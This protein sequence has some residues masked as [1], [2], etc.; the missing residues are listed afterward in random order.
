MNRCTVGF[1]VVTMMLF[2]IVG[3]HR[4]DVVVVVSYVDAKLWKSMIL[5][6]KWKSEGRSK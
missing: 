3:W 6:W 4:R 5:S 1:V 2:A